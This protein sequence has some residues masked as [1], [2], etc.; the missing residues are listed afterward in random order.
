LTGDRPDE[1]AS[2]RAADPTVRGL[3]GDVGP[4]HRPRIPADFIL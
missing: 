4:L 2:A 3:S 1:P